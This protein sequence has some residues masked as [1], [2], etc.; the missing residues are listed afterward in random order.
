MAKPATGQ[1][2]FTLIEMMVV[3]AVL[4]ILAGIALPSYTRYVER[5]N[6]ANAHAELV[7]INHIIKQFRVANPSGEGEDSDGNDVNTITTAGLTAY[8]AGLTIE[9]TVRE[10]YQISAAIPDNDSRRYNL[11]AEP[12]AATGYSK[13]VWMSSTGNAYRCSSVSDAKAYETSGNCEAIK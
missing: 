9:P 5:G 6:L 13:A 2:G 8:I 4:G 3:V 10:K 11:L 12:L 7:K 1:Y